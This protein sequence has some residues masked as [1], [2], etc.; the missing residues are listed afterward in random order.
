MALAFNYMTC[1]SV[2]SCLVLMLCDSEQVDVTC[3]LV[4]SDVT[5]YHRAT[6]AA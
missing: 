2:G 6:Q 5:V 4:G 1:A 3:L